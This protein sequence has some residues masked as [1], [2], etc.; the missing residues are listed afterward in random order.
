MRAV[1]AI[2][3]AGGRSVRMGQ[4]K[5]ALVVDGRRLVERAIDAL[6]PLGGRIIVARGDQPSL[7]LSD[8]VA[9]DPD[10]RGPLAGVVAAA[11]L[12]TAEVV[13]VV[14]V[15]MPQ[16]NSAVLTR[17]A[18]AMLAAGRPAAMPV[19]AGVPQPMHAVVSTAAL[20]GL[21]TVARSGERSLRRVLARL[22]ALLVG[23]EGWLDLDAAGRFATDWDTPDDLPSDVRVDAIG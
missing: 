21:V 22:D 4:D 6:R 18:D 14:A 7:G 20:P 5:A 3:L 1:D 12:I 8:E 11:A 17:L 10:V 13:A 19:V 16:I 9:D 23:P 2:L 15:D